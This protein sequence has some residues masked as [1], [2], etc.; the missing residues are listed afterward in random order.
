MLGSAMAR[1]LWTYTSF[2]S[3]SLSFPLSLSVSPPHT[4]LA[5]VWQLRP[6]VSREAS[7]AEPLSPGRPNRYLEQGFSQ[8]ASLSPANPFGLRNKSQGTLAATDTLLCFPAI[9]PRRRRTGECEITR[10]K[11][12]IGTQ[13]SIIPTTIISITITQQYSY[14]HYSYSCFHYYHYSHFCSDCC[15]HYSLMPLILLLLLCF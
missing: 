9:A 5:G 4:V 11:S 1:I 12:W 7:P 2:V 15:Y 6:Q 10:S 8:G 14:S 13:F 3:L